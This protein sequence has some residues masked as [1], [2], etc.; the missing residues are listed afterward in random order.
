MPAEPEDAPVAPRGGV[1]VLGGRGGGAGGLVG[2][3]DLVG[4]AFDGLALGSTAA[5]GD[6]GVCGSRPG[7]A[8]CSMAAFGHGLAVGGVAFGSIVLTL[9]RGAFAT[10]GAFALAR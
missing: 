9:P 3:R 5:G 2:D 6:G 7:G 8:C 10:A 4:L 1:G